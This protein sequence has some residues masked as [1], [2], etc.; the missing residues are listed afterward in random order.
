MDMAAQGRD[1]QNELDKLPGGGQIIM[2][3]ADWVSPTNNPQKAASELE[4]MLTRMH[5]PQYCNNAI[6][7][8]EAKHA[9]ENPSLSA[10]EIKQ[11][12][13][14][15]IS[16]LSEIEKFADH[17][18]SDETKKECE[19]Y[20]SDYSNNVQGPRGFTAAIKRPAENAHKALSTGWNPD[21]IEDYTV[22]KNLAEDAAKGVRNIE[23]IQGILRDYHADGSVRPETF[24][25]L[26]EKLRTLS[27]LNPDKKDFK[28]PAEFV[29]YA[30]SVS[31]AVKDLMKE[32]LKPEVEASLQFVSHGIIMNMVQNQPGFEEGV[33]TSFPDR[34]YDFDDMAVNY[35]NS[36][37]HNLERKLD[38]EAKGIKVDPQN[39]DRLVYDAPGL[40]QKLNDI[41]NFKN[42]I[43]SRRE[44]GNIRDCIRSHKERIE[45]PNTGEFEGKDTVLRCLDMLDDVTTGNAGEYSPSEINGAINKICHTL[46][47]LGDMQGMN[48]A[49][50]AILGSA[51]TAFT[52]IGNQLNQRYHLDKMDQEKTLNEQRDELKDLI[53]N[54][55]YEKYVTAHQ[56][57][58]KA[59]RA[60]PLMYLGV[61]IDPTAHYT[62][63]EKENLKRQILQ[64]NRVAHF[65]VH[66]N[67]INNVNEFQVRSEVMNALNDGWDVTHIDN[68]PRLWKIGK[69][70]EKNENAVQQNNIEN[71]K[72]ERMNSLLTELARYCPGTGIVPHNDHAMSAE[73]KNVRMMY[74]VI[75]VLEEA[76][77]PEVQK[78]M[79]ECRNLPGFEGSIYNALSCS[80]TDA[81][82]LENQK[83]LLNVRDTTD[84]I[85]ERFFGN[86]NI[87]D[88]YTKVGLDRESEVAGSVRNKADALRERFKDNLDNTRE[89]NSDE[90]LSMRSSLEKLY[91]VS[92][93]D[94]T[95]AT[96]MS[97]LK[98]LKKTAS[99]YVETRDGAFKHNNPR[100]VAAK[101][102]VELAENA[103]RDYNIVGAVG[104]DKNLNTSTMSRRNLMSIQE[105]EREK[106]QQDFLDDKITIEKYRQNEISRRNAQKELSHARKS[107]ITNGIEDFKSTVLEIKNEIGDEVEFFKNDADNR[108]TPRGSR[109]DEYNDLDKF[110]HSIS[111]LS[112]DQNGID[113]RTP[114]G[115]YNLMKRTMEA[116]KTYVEKH[117]GAS[118]PLSAVSAR[119]ERRLNNA[120]ALYEKLR[121]SMVKL[122][123]YYASVKDLDP[124]KKIGQ[125]LAD[126]V[127]PEENE[128]LAGLDEHITALQNRKNPPVV[129]QDGPQVNP[130][131]NP[132]VNPQVDN[133]EQNIQGNPEQIN[134]G[135]PE[136]NIQNNPEL[137][138][139]GNIIIN[140]N[141]R[142]NE[143]QIFEEENI[144][145]DN[146]ADNN[147]NINNNINNNIN[148]GGDDSFALEGN[149]NIGDIVNDKA[150]DNLNIGD[151]IK[152]KA[153]NNAKEDVKDQDK[154]KAF[155]ESRNKKYEEEKYPEMNN[156]K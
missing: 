58:F 118:H 154:M 153:D 84:Y 31:T 114:A 93:R 77:K 151:I 120:K 101:E 103:L 78:A 142:I 83:T 40:Q 102:L 18:L 150:F 38:F 71:P 67:V 27:E 115:V 15:A 100:V 79:K 136:Q 91:G 109:A 43:K 23:A 63:A 4:D 7:Y 44:Q 10:T 30:Q 87:Q 52:D 144:N 80:R 156:V 42:D 110:T 25:G 69:L 111:S 104:L 135:N 95:P 46:N 56:G 62:D 123:R 149:L 133:P 68:V 137:N 24:D 96:M 81:A 141:N 139:G 48:N 70:I 90:Y 138:N 127:D 59:Y 74:A 55:T 9:L 29:T 39:P 85:R 116:A 147:I 32:R 72:L 45:H 57:K 130:P 140:D 105:K 64:Y 17:C 155:K 51:R 132:Q 108:R 11:H 53:K 8:M 20:Y 73:E 13:N 94:H 54:R 35:F 47:K 97:A 129:V 61:E 14:T 28:S 126:N 21:Y 66:D 16:A 125:H 41:L 106:D 36:R 145:I 49:D 152:D 26:K 148:I 19:K 37:M 82:D 124:G 65:D 99:Y 5:W 88:I 12:S 112:F 146:V 92:F 75:D 50:K 121:V 107:N 89:R 117:E 86:K 33:Y 2:N 60:E 76:K 113:Q 131:V 34:L 1:V 122:D 119:G 134:Q 128:F 6:N 143:E 3:V 22:I 98:E